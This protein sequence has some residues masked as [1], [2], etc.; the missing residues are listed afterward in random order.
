MVMV[1]VTPQTNVPLC[2]R[3]ELVGS[4]AGKWNTGSGVDCRV[5]RS[6]DPLAKLPQGVHVLYSTDGTVLVLCRSRSSSACPPIRYSDNP[7]GIPSSIEW[8]VETNHGFPLSAMVDDRGEQGHDWEQ[9]TWSDAHVPKRCIGN[10]STNNVSIR[11]ILHPR[12]PVCMYNTSVCNLNVTCTVTYWYST[13][14]QPQAAASHKTSRWLILLR[15]SDRAARPRSTVIFL[16]SFRLQHVFRTLH[17]PAPRPRSS[18]WSRIASFAVRVRR[19]HPVRSRRRGSKPLIPSLD[20]TSSIN[21]SLEMADPKSRAFPQGSPRQIPFAES[22]CQYP[23]P[24]RAVLPSYRR[25]RQ[26]LVLVP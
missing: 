17:R 26:S 18:H 16:P 4:E 7:V 14:W 11:D 1:M 24:N 12:L 9:R 10:E 8:L 6:R 3:H 25:V 22:H 13:S 23:L 15:T 5:E 20:E 21:T 2:K 19:C